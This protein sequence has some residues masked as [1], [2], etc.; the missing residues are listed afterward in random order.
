[1]VPLFTINAL[2]WEPLPLYG[3]GLQERDRFFV[4]DHAA[5]LDLLLHEGAVGESYNVG[6]GNYATNIEVA[7]RICELLDRPT[8]LIRPVLD[9]PGH[10]RRYRLDTAK[11]RSLG[12]SPT[13]D[14]EATLATTVHWYRDHPEWWRPLRTRMHGDWYG[15]QYGQRLRS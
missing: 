13:H 5:A 14:L 4:E 9:R 7:R 3:D 10:D 11:L 15:R 1:M 6:A 8:D 2:T 12:W